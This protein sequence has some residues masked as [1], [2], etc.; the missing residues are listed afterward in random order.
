[1]VSW[2]CLRYRVPGN[3]PWGLTQLYASSLSGGER[4][5]L[6]TLLIW[7]TFRVGATWV[8]QL[9]IPTD[10]ARLLLLLSTSPSWRHSWPC[11]RAT[12]HI[13]RNATDRRCSDCGEHFPSVLAHTQAPLHRVRHPFSQVLPSLPNFQCACS[14]LVEWGLKNYAKKKHCF[15]LRVWRSYF[16]LLKG[17]PCRCRRLPGLPQLLAGLKVHWTQGKS[18]VH[19]IFKHWRTLFP[20]TL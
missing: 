19:I 4:I 5:F 10:P 14:P 13:F 3:A 18:P 8:M 9:C 6:L 15:N 20:V 16:Q 12:C 11:Q 17:W 7:R 2:Y 1:M